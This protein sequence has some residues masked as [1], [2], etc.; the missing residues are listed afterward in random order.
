M[1]YFFMPMV[2]WKVFEK[3]F[4]NNLLMLNVEDTK[5]V[6]KKAKLK[7]RQIIEE[8]PPWG[9]NDVL[10][11]NILS[12]ATLASIYLS[13]PKK[14]DVKQVE[15]YYRKSMNE[16]KIMRFTLKNTKNFSKRQQRG[17]SKQASKSQKATNPYTW[18]YEFY[19][20]KNI[21]NFD[22][23]FDKCGIYELFK[24]LGISDITPALCAYD[25]GMA[26]HTN[27]IFTRECTIASGGEVC[28]CHYK[29]KS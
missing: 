22:A 8:I 26:E 17:L 2:M 4:Q 3:S 18:R 1:K 24:H 19:Y 16:N 5:P 21:D 15:E 25:Y 28:D 20:G 14:V 27:T 29:R 11:V 10:L 23:I 7:Y 12:G 13:L 9:K 6:M